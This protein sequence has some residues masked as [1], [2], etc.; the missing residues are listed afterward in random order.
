MTPQQFEQLL[1][2]KAKEIEAYAN[3]VCP[4]QAGN[5]ALR[6]IDKNFREQKYQG[7]TQ[8]W[9]ENKRGGTI[10]VKSGHLR[11]ANYY[12]TQPGQAT[13]RNTMPYAKIHNEGGK[14]TGTATVKTHT[15]KAHTRTR[16]GKREVVK[17]HTVKAHTRRMNLT[18]PQRQFFPIE[19]QSNTILNDAVLKK[20]ETELKRIFS[21][22]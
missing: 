2:T 6:F 12:T 11:S 7:D 4:T 5:E 16:K 22:I 20:I 1:K 14:I 10:L 17:G 13:V 8:G 21:T 9:K 19:G 3:N 18:M 15:V